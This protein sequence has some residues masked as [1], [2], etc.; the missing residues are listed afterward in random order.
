MGG[1][2]M[3]KKILVIDDEES[4]REMC[5]MILCK[6]ND[7]EVIEAVDGN[8]GFELAKLEKPDLIILDNR[9][10]IMSGEETAKLL[11]ADPSTRAIPIIMITAMRLSKQEIA[12]IK[13]DVNDFI[14][15]PFSPWEL[16]RSVE[17][18]LGTLSE[19]L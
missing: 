18:Y 10:R 4:A 9:M 15:K 2:M 6:Y 11:R 16:V 8:K 7:I 19:K 13:M 14:E 5:R 12:F 3:R 1:S 17:K